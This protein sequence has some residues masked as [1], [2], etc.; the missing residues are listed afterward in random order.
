VTLVKNA[1][2]LRTA[3]LAA[4][5]SDPTRCYCPSGITTH[6]GNI[7]PATLGAPVGNCANNCADGTA[8]GYY[9]TITGTYTL[10][11]FLRIGALSTTGKTISETV[12]VRLK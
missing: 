10:T 12:T 7:V 3:S 8:P 4:T 5:A 1:S 2:S 6:D 9:M 11:G